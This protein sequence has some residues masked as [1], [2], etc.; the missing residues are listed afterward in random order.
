MVEQ[1]IN[2]TLKQIEKKIA[3]VLKYYIPDTDKEEMKSI[4]N[5]LMADKD[6]ISENMKSNQKIVYRKY[7]KR[8]WDTIVDVLQDVDIVKH[9]CY[10][11]NSTRNYMRMV[12]MYDRVDEDV[13]Y[14]LVGDII[15]KVN[16]KLSQVL[17]ELE[18]WHE[19][20]TGPE[21]LKNTTTMFTRM[22][23]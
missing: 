11:N 1:K 4:M 14:D 9:V 15:S 2:K 16:D 12:V 21:Y 17:I 13:A 20:E 3:V 19:S 7:S 8:I 23:V 18:L 22:K 6:I 5:Y 10:Q